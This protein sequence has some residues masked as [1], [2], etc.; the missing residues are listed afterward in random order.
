M[1]EKVYLNEYKAF[2]TAYQQGTTSAEDI[3]LVITRMAQYFAETN[4]QLSG[5]DKML[6][7]V[8]ARTVQSLDDATG[9]AISVAKAELLIRAT[10]EAKAYNDSKA[11]LQNIEQFINALKYLQKGLLNEY[12]HV[13][14]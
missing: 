7:D 9:K 8:S 1:D 11:D 12:A 2:L 5:R 6:N 14:T 4:L 10:P 3:G 13:G